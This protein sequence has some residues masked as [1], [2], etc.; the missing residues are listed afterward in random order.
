V[1]LLVATD[2]AAR[3]LDIAELAA[4]VNYDLPPSASNAPTG[5]SGR[6]P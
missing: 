2:L 1:Q 5:S 6:A 4:V 3:G